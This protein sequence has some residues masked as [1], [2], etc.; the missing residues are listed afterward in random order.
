MTASASR[1]AK[2]NRKPERKNLQQ[3]DRP[4]RGGTYLQPGSNLDETP[5]SDLS[6]NQQAQ[7]AVQVKSL[8]IEKL[9][10]QIAKLRRMQFGRS[11]ERITRQ[12]EQ[13]E[14]QLE[15][16]ETGEAEDI[17]G[18]EG[19]EPT[20]PI[21][22]RKKPKRKPLP[23][24]LPR[25]EVLHEPEAGFWQDWSVPKESTFTRIAAKKS[26]TKSSTFDTSRVFRSD[27]LTWMQVEVDMDYQPFDGL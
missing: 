18:M 14:L 19:D 5:G 17:A 9:R 7:L 20:A 26:A 10:F 6:E 8:E 13:L 2:P 16:L 27:L 11:S 3:L 25:H 22:E 4:T 1:T 15:E 12:I 24:H 23:D 21:P